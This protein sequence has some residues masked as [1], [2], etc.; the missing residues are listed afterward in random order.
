MDDFIEKYPEVWDLIIHMNSMI[1][2]LMEE[3]KSLK[4]EVHRAELL[5]GTCRKTIFDNMYTINYMAK[6]LKDVSAI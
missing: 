2:G 3:N 1:N 6:Y 4:E 5:N